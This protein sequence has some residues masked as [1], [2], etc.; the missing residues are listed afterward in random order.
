MFVFFGFSISFLLALTFS[1]VTVWV[2]RKEAGDY[3]AEDWNVLSSVLMVS[4]VALAVAGLWLVPV[5]QS[6]I[7]AAWFPLA[8]SS[9]VMLLIA[10]LLN[11]R[12]NGSSG[13]DG[14]GKALMQ[15][16]AARRRDRSHDA[17]I[18]TAGIFSL[19]FWTLCAFSGAIL[20]IEG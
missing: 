4:F 15:P 13:D 10:A 12:R 18:G 8:L 9:L 3:R 7:G 14:R 11:P 6:Y 1:A 16:F 17:A 2:Y 19:Y 5:A 20:M